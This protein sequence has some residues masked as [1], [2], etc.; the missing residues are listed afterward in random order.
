MQG[1][2]VT[3]TVSDPDITEL[4]DNR[5]IWL[6]LDGKSGWKGK[7]YRY[8]NNGVDFNRDWGYM[9]NGEGSVPEP[10]SQ[11]ESKSLSK[12]HV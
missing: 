11:V 7:C 3:I 6:I 8:N 10:C 5:E 12:L 4:I 2:F 1:I 9:W